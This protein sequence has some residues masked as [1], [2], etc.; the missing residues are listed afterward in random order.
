MTVFEEIALRQSIMFGGLS[1]GFL[2]AIIF[3]FFFCYRG[4]STLK[5]FIKVLT[6][7]AFAVAGYVNFAAPLVVLGL[8]VSAIGD[9]FL[10]RDGKK[11]FLTGLIAFAAAHVFYIAHFLPM[12]SLADLTWLPAV[13]LVVLAVSTE[14]WLIPYTDDMAWPVR[15]YVLLITVMGCAALG[16]SGREIAVLG[17]FAFIL[18]DLILAINLFRLPPDSRLRIPS[19][20]ALWIFYVLGQA[21]ILIGAGFAQPLFSI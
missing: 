11:S 18:S 14:R 10:S 1:F 12:A 9:A 7:L 8:L 16:L 3:A 4:P 6:P 20:I 17:A 15:I 21:G 2:A 19:E 5:T 13:L